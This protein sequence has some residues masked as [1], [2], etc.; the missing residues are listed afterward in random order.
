MDD[1][2]MPERVFVQE[3]MFYDGETHYPCSDTDDNGA[4]PFIRADLVP[5]WIKCSER[6]PEEWRLVDCVYSYKNEQ[7][8]F[9]GKVL[10]GDWHNDMNQPISSLVTVTH[11]RERPEYPTEEV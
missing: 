11:W 9:I 7:H 1:T 4:T 2:K 6:M 5:Q 3:G 10:N 8:S